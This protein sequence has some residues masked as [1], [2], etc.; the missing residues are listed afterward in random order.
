MGQLMNQTILFDGRNQYDP[1][2]MSEYGFEYH[3]IGRE[4]RE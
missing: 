3:G 2:E 1:E 4:S